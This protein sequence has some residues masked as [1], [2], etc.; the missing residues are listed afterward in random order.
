MGWVISVYSQAAFKEYVL[1]SAQNEDY[2]LTIRANY[3]QIAEDLKIYFEV[4]SGVWSLKRQR[5]YSV[6]QD[7][8]LRESAIIKDDSMLTVHSAHQEEIQLFARQ[9]AQFLHAYHKYSLAGVSEV[10]IGKD[11][12]NDICYDSRNMVSRRHAVIRKSGGG[13]CVSNQGQNGVY[14]NSSLVMEEKELDFG[15]YINILGL[16]LVY[17]GDVLAVDIEDAAAVINDRLLRPLE[18]KENA[19]VYLEKKNFKTLPGGITYHRA[20]RNYEKLDAGKIEIEP[21]PEREQEKRQSLFMSIGPS[22]TM[23]LPMLL[24][25]LLMVYSNGKSGGSTSLYM[26]SGLIMSVSSAAVGLAWTLVNL[27][28]EKRERREK[29]EYRF[30]TYSDY[31]VEKTDEIR[32][33]YEDTVRRLQETYPDAMACLRYD[34]EKGCLWNRNDAHD[35]FLSHRLGIGRRPFQYQI[36]IPKKKFALYQDQL[37]T[38]PRYIKENFQN[39]IDVPITVDLLEKHLVGIVGGSGKEGAIHVAKLLTAQIASNNCYSD[40]KLAYIYDNE[41]SEDFGNWEYVKWLPHVWSED[42]RVRYVAENAEDASEVFY[43]LTKVFRG[44]E[45]DASGTERRLDPHYVVFVSKPD[46]LESGSFAKYAFSESERYGLTTVIL[47]DYKE[48]LPNECEF[49]LE[50]S[51]NFKGAYHI[52]DGKNGRQEICYDQM[53]D[54]L[55]E[56]FA[57]HSSSLHV[58][59]KEQGGEIPASITFFEMFHIRCI[60]EYPVREAWAKS[61]TY[62]SIKGLL[63]QRAGGAPCYLDMHEKYHG[64][65]GLVAGTTGSGKSE[66]LQ[67]YILSLAIN[68]SPDDI[69]FF[70]I[71]YKGGGMANLFDGLPHMIGSISNLSGNQVKRAMISIKSENRRRQRV[72]T[73]HGVNN[74]NLYTKMYKN[75]EAMMPIPHLFIIID[76]FAELKREEPEFMKELI[77]VAQVGRSLGVHLILATQKP[78]GTVDDNIWSNSKFRLCLRVQDQQDSKDML[79]RPD[80]AYITQAGRGYLQVGND[81]VYELF[82]SGFSGAVFDQNM[83]SMAGEIAKLITMP[84]KVET[85]GNSVKLSRKKHAETLWIELLCKT[86]S[87][88]IKDHQDEVKELADHES[89]IH[90]AMK[91]MKCA[92]AGQ[93]IDYEDNEY[94]NSRLKDFINLYMS[95]GSAQSVSAKAEAVIL[96]AAEKRV[97]LP[98][99]KE[100][101]QL[102]V[103]KEFLSEIARKNG[104]SHKFS[105]WLPVLRKQISLQKFAEYEDTCFLRSHWEN[106]A[107]DVGMQILI[108][109]VDDPENQSQ[110]PLMFDFVKQGHVAVIGSVASGKSTLMQTMVYG[111]IQKYSPAR[112]NIYALDFSSRTLSAFEDAPHVGG[113]MYEGDEK[114]ICKFFNMMGKI[115]RERKDL[116]KGGNYKQYVQKNEKLLPAIV[117]LIDNYAGFKE[118]TGQMYEDQLIQLSKEG[119]SLGIYLIVSGSGFGYNDI[120][121]RV[122]EN[123]ENVFCLALQ[124]KYAYGELLHNMKIDIMPEIGI[125]GRGLAY[126]GSRILEYQ[127]ALACEAENDYQ[128]MEMIQS[129]CEKMRGAWSEVS[130]RRIPEIPAEPTWSAFAQLPAYRELSASKDVLPVA[131]D[132]ADAEVYG[133]PLRDIY[134]YLIT[135]GSGMGKSN[136]MR[137][138][139]QSV[140]AKKAHVCI[141]DGSGKDMRKYAQYENIVYASEEG[142]AFDYFRDILTPVFQERNKAKNDMLA[143]DYDESEIY[144]HMR[145]KEAYF[146]FISDLRWFVNMVY[147]SEHN[148]S[149]F[150]ETLVSKG[151]YHNIYFVAEISINKISE[152]KGYKLYESFAEYQCGVHFGGRVSENHIMPFEYMQYKEQAALTPV[153]TAVLPGTASYAGTKK[154]VVP[155][156]R[157]RGDVA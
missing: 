84:G 101:T 120:S 50:N 104:Y 140:L 55:L 156:A 67:T 79:H 97:R 147:A 115:V 139:I 53:D 98:Q 32:H 91:G 8:I 100:K 24:G 11:A 10:S 20:P 26:Y 60:Q 99:P 14:V 68:Y 136:Y 43:E 71:D 38:E 33:L 135:G 87:E 114:K 76:E 134:C 119:V 2:S 125:Q 54:Q 150:M 49:I 92:L 40:V 41:T 126:Y 61:K 6:E 44:R 36:E 22:L 69:G 59:E 31:L 106:I 15:A 81:E 121:S 144:E 146:I 52:Y 9:T 35:D 105:L 51:A 42:R 103:T 78:S 128:R 82:Q 88:L 112:I 152:V 12:A 131:Y 137:V 132:E 18:I 77:S 157:K 62:E 56:Q 66:T 4:L 143:Q 93:E 117:F 70:I 29:E 47:T 45:E 74:I 151:R 102:D 28:N 25:C 153:G 124:D 5:G 80:A 89:R 155:L 129:V 64:P 13:Y 75:G 122:G 83:T 46:F 16:H 133:I 145:E 85:T 72:F 94:N 27:K 95:C 7:G 3:F 1:P 118:K 141:L 138:M 108:G 34:E 19:T 127:V 39:L 17:L 21:P 113:I 109:M 73:E 154:I 130:V 58:A 123:I 116:F 107:E 65:H 90:F 111:L 63:G 37:T 23:S 149:G 48:H 96:S 110:M 86:L 57:R 30:Q 142:Q 148:L